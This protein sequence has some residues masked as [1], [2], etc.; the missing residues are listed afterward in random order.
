[1]STNFIWNV[2][3]IYCYPEYEGETDVATVVKWTY[4]GVDAN[5]VSSVAYGLTQLPAWQ[6]G[7]PFIPYDQLTEAEV[8]SWFEPLVPATTVSS[9]QA[10]IEV[11]IAQKNSQ[12][13]PLPWGAQ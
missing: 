12:T 10:E 5:E 8:I 4:T 3:A 6:P 11:A 2:S 1:M 13:K 9:M 7:S